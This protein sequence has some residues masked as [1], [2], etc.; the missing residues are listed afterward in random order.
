MSGILQALL[1]SFPSGD[2]Y[3]LWAWGSDNSGGLGLGTNF[4]PRSSPNQIGSLTNWASVAT[5]AGHSGAVDQDNKLYMWGANSDGA[6]GQGNTISK[7]SPVQVGSLTNW[8]KVAPGNLFTLSLKTDGTLWS[9]GYNARGQLGQSN[10]TSISSPAQVGAL[11]TWTKISATGSGGNSHAIRNDG[12]LWAWGYNGAGALGTYNRTSRSSPVQVGFEQG[13][14]LEVS[15]NANSTAGTTVDLEGGARLYTWGTNPD[16]QLGHNNLINRSAPVRVGLLTDWAKPSVGQ[17][18]M[19]ATKTNNTLW[20]W[21]ANGN[22]ELGLNDR[23]SRSSPVQIGALTDWAY[24]YAGFSHVLAIKT[25]GTLWAW[26]INSTGELGQGGTTN[27]SS[28]VQVG[29]LTT[30]Y[31]A[32]AG[33]ARSFGITKN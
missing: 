23:T 22:G 32:A 17:N 25:N 2:A 5:G 26:G 31:A 4:V 19:V 30:W 20:S 21:G 1:A 6:L 16:G 12:T 3:R 10:T 11:T 27:R 9:W 24:A 14:W 8:D 29:S 15:T 7:S 13:T 18:F 28:P 33:S